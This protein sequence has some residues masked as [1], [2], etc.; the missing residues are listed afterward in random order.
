MALLGRVANQTLSAGGLPADSFSPRPQETHSGL[1]LDNAV[2]I[3]RANPAWVPKTRRPG[4]L[5]ESTRRRHAGCF[6]TSSLLLLPEDAPL[7]LLENLQNCPFAEF[8]RRCIDQGA[9]GMR[10]T[11]LF[12]NDLT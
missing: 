5:V 4:I 11:S 1:R 2:L 10:I 7:V 12:A 3:L 6:R 9:Q 8:R